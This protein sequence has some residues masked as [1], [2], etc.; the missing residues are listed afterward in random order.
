MW[1][2][3]MQCNIEMYSTASLNSHR[4]FL[5]TFILQ[6]G[7]RIPLSSCKIQVVLCGTYAPQIVQQAGFAPGSSRPSSISVVSA[8]VEQLSEL[9]QGLQKVRQKGLQKD[10]G[11]IV[12]HARLTSLSPVLAICSE[13]TLTLARNGF[14]VQ[15]MR[16][17]MRCKVTIV[18]L[19]TLQICLRA[20]CYLPLVCDKHP[21]KLCLHPHD[22]FSLCWPSWAS[23][24]LYA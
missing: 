21:L 12:A 19:F 15:G 20:H 24:H 7:H 6:E 4:I 9:P 5:F 22:L 3:A 18:E 10:F 16:K 17:C 2:C 23:P 13:Q 1:L 11:L 8:R 14:G